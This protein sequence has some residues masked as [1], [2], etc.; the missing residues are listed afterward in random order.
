ML[1]GNVATSRA[2]ENKVLEYD[3]INMRFTNDDGA[4]AYLDKEY[5]RGFGLV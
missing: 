4:N 5:R 3:A 2:G 1:L